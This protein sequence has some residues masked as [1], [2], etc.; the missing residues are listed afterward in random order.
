MNYKWFLIGDTYRWD[1][2]PRF[3]K[4]F[5]TDLKDKFVFWRDG[6]SDTEETTY[7]VAVLNVAFD[8]DFRQDFKDLNFP[9]DDAMYNKI[10][11]VI[12]EY[13]G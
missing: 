10:Y 11:P 3:Y 8:H 4:G 12:K 9:I 1:K 2:F 6:V 13:V 7:M 5:S